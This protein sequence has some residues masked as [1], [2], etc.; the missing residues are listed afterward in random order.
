[1]KSLR[2]TPISWRFKAHPIFDSYAATIMAVALGYNFARFDSLRAA[3][4]GQRLNSISVE[5]RE[6]VICLLN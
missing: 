3:A 4:I 2:G 1:V 5:E 6:A